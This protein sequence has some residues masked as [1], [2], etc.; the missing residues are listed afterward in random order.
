M[1]I[2]TRDTHAR[3][4]FRRVAFSLLLMLLPL[5]SL[6]SQETTPPATSSANPNSG[7]NSEL[8][9]VAPL[10]TFRLQAGAPFV[11]RA[12]NDGYVKKVDVQRGDR[13]TRDQPLVEL[14]VQRLELQ[15]PHLKAAFLK[16]FDAYR[17]ATRSQDQLAIAQAEAR[18]EADATAYD[19]LVFEIAQHRLSAPI[20][21]YLSDLLVEPGQFVYK[22][23][24]VASIADQ[25]IVTVDLP[26]SKKQTRLGEKVALIVD[27][28]LVDGVI[29]RIQPLTEAHA[30]ARKLNEQLVT[31][32]IEIK[33][34]GEF[35]AGQSV[36]PVQD[37]Y[38]IVPIHSIIVQPDG[39]TLLRVMRGNE[40]VDLPAV[41]LASLKSREQFV[42][43]DLM[44]AD[45]AVVPGPI[46]TI[47]M[48]ETLNDLGSPEQSSLLTT[49]SLSVAEPELL[50]DYSL[51]FNP[52]NKALNEEIPFD[53]P[54][55]LD[56]PENLTGILSPG[57]FPLA[58][59][60]L[61]PLISDLDLAPSDRLAFE[62][63]QNEFQQMLDEKGLHIK[64][65]SDLK[66]IE[67]IAEYQTF[68]R[69][70]RA[71]NQDFANELLRELP[72]ESASE[73]QNQILSHFGLTEAAQMHLADSLEIDT[74]KLSELEQQF[75]SEQFD[76]IKKLLNSEVVIDQARETM[77]NLL[78]KKDQAVINIVP[79]Q[80]Q[81]LLAVSI[82]QRQARFDQ[83]SKPQ[84]GEPKPMTASTSPTKTSSQ[85]KPY[86]PPP[87]FAP[88]PIKNETDPIMIG[89]FVLIG[90]I[91]LGALGYFLG[92]PKMIKA[93][94]TP[95][96]D[97]GKKKKKKSKLKHINRVEVGPEKDY[98]SIRAALAA[99]QENRFVQDE[100][101]WD[102]HEIVLDAGIYQETLHLD[103]SYPDSI[104]IIGAE[105]GQVT[106]VGDGVNPVIDAF[107]V[108]DFGLE[109]VIIDGEA[110]PT[111]IQLRD[112]NKLIT[113]SQVIITGFKQFGLRITNRDPEAELQVSL[114]ETLLLSSILDTTGIF[115]DYGSIESSSLVVDQCRFHGPMQVGIQFRAP[116]HQTTISETIFAFLT[117]AISL[118]GTSYPFRSLKLSNNTFFRCGR[119]LFFRR[120]DL[121]SKGEREVLLD[122][123]LFSRSELAD[124]AV[125]DVVDAETIESASDFIHNHSNG[126]LTDRDGESNYGEG[127]ISLNGKAARY[128]ADFKFRSIEVEEPDF[129]MPT[130]DSPQ[131]QAW[132]KKGLRG[133]VGAL[134]PKSVV[135]S[136][137]ETQP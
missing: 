89:L 52:E 66:E 91:V 58:D 69:A 4:L 27:R 55:S 43:A 110:A 92:L 84:V 53:A 97:A 100:I 101:A 63:L 31:A 1:T 54:S 57:Q 95:S 33:N 128:F 87:K 136:V 105:L 62:Q 15:L 73:F 50:Q 29:K 132:A 36:L 44:V 81:D 19:L 98:Q 64:D 117:T 8:S 2:S 70:I 126:N 120:V 68:L 135:K 28:Q 61:T 109:G 102:R 78:D 48:T 104:H 18:K 82:K 46:A 9:P 17:D 47:P 131:R 93:M 22:G 79:Q 13:I 12:R 39:V 6:S 49:E 40:P 60:D 103:E 72:E 85:E 116:L 86:E 96:A 10:L 38:A 21:G 35:Q 124:V 26:L 23:D 113:F 122:N 56:L 41:P 133:Y 67:G 129:L 94:M 114:S 108:V 80:A 71:I 20:G 25:R 130:P 134:G 14:D 123:N 90:L 30:L 119:G 137:M 32:T 127:I 74:A 111:V 75:E 42:M 107:H 76:L 51:A 115:I 3:R 45:L 112:A 11:V 118:A 37:P 16:S 77:K 34:T 125:S 59:L 65:L 88:P 121:M 83:L 24:P 106:I 99:V 5:V 7:D